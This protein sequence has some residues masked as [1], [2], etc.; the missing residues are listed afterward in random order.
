MTL[1]RID[2]FRAEVLATE[3]FNHLVVPNFVPENALP[4]ILADFPRIERG[5]SFPLTSLNYGSVFKQFCDQLRGPDLR[6]AFSE[7]LHIDLSDRPTTLT[8]RG[9]CRAKDGKIH[10]DS[11][12]KLVTVLIY[13]S[14][15]VNKTGGQLRLLRSPNI[16]DYFVQIPPIPGTLVC[17][18]NSPQAWHGH[19]SFCGE[20]RVLQ[21]NWVTDM[22]AVH[23]SERRHGVSAMFKRLNP[24]GRAA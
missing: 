21:L 19:K 10:T 15:P 7:K 4:K 16:E 6:D 20:R 24:F 11:K 8:V 17:F 9:T 23:R 1:I 2:R 12:S 3:P 14:G 5:G 13:L 22:A 18:E